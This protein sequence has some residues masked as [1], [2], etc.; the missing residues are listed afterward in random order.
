M[1]AFVRYIG[2]DYS[3]AETPEARLK[4]LRIFLAGADTQAEEVRPP[5]DAGKYWSRRGVAHWLAAHL[6]EDVPTLVGIDHS[7]S[8]P[9]RYLESHG[10]APDWQKFLEDFQ[11]HWP[12]DEP[13]MRVEFIRLGESGHGAERT[14]SSR[15]RRLADERTTAKSAFHFDVPGSVAKSTHAGLPWLLFLR[16]QMGRRVHFWPFDGWNIRGGSSAIVEAYPA[17]YA[18]T[19]PREDRSMDQHDAYAVASW[20]RD[21][22]QSGELETYLMPALTPAQRRVAEV[23]GWILGVR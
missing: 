11:H 18:P 22:D 9:M 1:A 13:R 16:R 20:L 15:W 6:S 7:F 3:G 8:F 12:T 14:G 4:G 2:I 21:I 5:A 19:Y 17:L 23:E 10:L